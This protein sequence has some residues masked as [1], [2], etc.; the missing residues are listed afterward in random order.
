MSLMKGLN[1][2]I[3]EK[4]KKSNPMMIRDSGSLQGLVP[5]SSGCVT[6][7]LASGFGGLVC[8]G[9][10]AEVIGANTSGKTTLCIQTAAQAQKAGEN[11]IYIDSEGVFDIK[12][13]TALGLD[14]DAESF[15]LL[16]PD[17]GEQIGEVLELLEAEL[18]STK[19]KDDNVG[20]VIIDSVATARPQE[21]LEGN[22]RIGQHAALWAKLAYKI[23]NVAK[24]FNIAFVLINQIRYAPSI[25]G[26]FSAPGVLDSSQNNDMGSEN[27]TGGETLK[28]LYSVRWQ[29]KGFAQIK[30]E[31]ADIM[32]G[33][34]GELRIGNT[35]NVT[36]IKNKLGIPMV[37]TKM[38]V[39]YGKGTVDYYVLEEILKA[40]GLISNSGA[41]KKYEVMDKSL[42]PNPDHESY[43]GFI[44]GKGKFEDWFRSEP[45][46]Q[47][48]RNQLIALVNKSTSTT[49]VN[50]EGESTVAD[51]TLNFDIEEPKE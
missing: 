1:S 3:K 48:A 46:Q 47:D 6:V 13:A 15:T 45:V 36:T 4:Y 44:Y 42:T 50:E 28:F 10:V 41:Y 20:L 39:V 38:S 35:V 40:R 22:K 5:L 43:P 31:S 29:L 27:T 23:K 16:Q 30:E 7:D 2:K 18:K 26:G 33:E 37:K 51:E 49:E 24:N 8:K 19:S 17:Y 11:V 21:E 14:V 12:Y 32:T 25:G 9:H 34:E